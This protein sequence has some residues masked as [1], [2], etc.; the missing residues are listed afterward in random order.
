VFAPID[1]L[2]AD[3]Q[4]VLGRSGEGTFRVRDTGARLYGYHLTEG[5]ERTIPICHLVGG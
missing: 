4:V 1:D 5:F 2:F 3:A